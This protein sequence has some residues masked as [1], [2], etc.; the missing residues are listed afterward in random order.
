MKMS[1]SVTELS[2]PDSLHTL[3]E[4]VTTAVIKHKPVDTAEFVALYFQDFIAFHRDNLNL[5]LQ[6]VVKKFDFKY[7]NLTGE[8]VRKASYH[9]DTS[10]SNEP[11]KKEAS[12]D[13][14]E[15][16]LLEDLAIEYSSKVI[17][18]P[19]AVSSVAEN[20]PSTG[21]DGASS[22]E[23]PELAYVPADP[24]QLAAHVLGNSDSAYSVR[25]VATSVQTLD[26][27]S[28]ASENSFALVDNADEDAA[29]ALAAGASVEAVRSQ[30]GVQHCS[31]V[32]GEPGPS[33]SQADVST[34]DVKQVSSVLLQ[35]EPLPF[36]PPPP[37]P[38][39]LSS[40]GQLQAA[41]SGSAAEAISTTEGCNKPLVDAEVPPFIEQFPEKIIIPFIEQTAYLLKIEQPLNASQ[42]SCAK[43]LGPPAAAA[44][45]QPERTESTAHMESAEQVYVMSG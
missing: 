10:L 35:E 42:V 32:A 19:S 12:T 38:P 22:P 2:V 41:P 5:D 3:L 20:K 18:C 1:L 45:C 29:A 7:E 9:R 11:Q 43:T 26:E 17:Q 8:L 16:Q 15:D 25:D 31:S 14:E 27:D 39:S 44:V 24:E 40:Q 13:T 4:G 23:G 21:P 33:D 34:D 36:P 6:E 28:Q 37:P 30:P